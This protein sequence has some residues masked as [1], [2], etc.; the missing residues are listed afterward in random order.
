ML[1]HAPIRIVPSLDFSGKGIAVHRLLIKVA[2][3]CGTALHI[4]IH[5]LVVNSIAVCVSTGASVTASVTC[6][7][8]SENNDHLMQ[9]HL[10]CRE[11]M[12]ALKVNASRKQCACDAMG[13]AELPFPPLRGA[14]LRHVGLIEAGC[15]CGW[16]CGVA[17]S[18]TD[19]RAASLKPNAPSAII[20]LPRQ[21]R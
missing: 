10:Y 8:T 4:D 1:L 21:R 9:P 17:A 16:H 12:V 11:I 3:V 13:F 15:R 20:R 19:S 5:L 6:L 7:R 14:S 2:R 18:V